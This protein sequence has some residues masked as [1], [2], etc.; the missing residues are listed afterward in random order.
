MGAWLKGSLSGLLKSVLSER[1]V[2]ARGLLD[3]AVVRQVIAAHE[4]NREDHTDHL[5]ALLNLEIW[6]RIY[7]DQ[8][9]PDDIALELA[10]AI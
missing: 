3:H 6:C 7:L 8:R 4:Q 5:I 2:T 10:E 1:S 9:S